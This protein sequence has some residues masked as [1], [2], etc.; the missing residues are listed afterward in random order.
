[1]AN[2]VNFSQVRSN[3]AGIDIGSREIFVSIDGVSAV[4]FPTYTADYRQ[5]C[6][7]LL[8]HGITDVAM[9]ATG[10]Y[11]ISLYCML[12]ESGIYVCLVHPREVQQVKGRKSDVQDCQ[13]IQRLFVSGLLRESLIPS[14]LLKE[15]RYLSRERED[16]IQTGSM[17]VNKMQRALELMNIKLGN[18]ISQ[19]HGASGLKVLHAILEGERDP[20]VLLSLCHSSIRHKKGEDVKKALE[21]N[22][23]ASYLY[24][25]KLNLDMWEFFQQKLLEVEQEMEKLLHVLNEPGKDIPVESKSKPAR[26]HNP[27]IK[28]LHVLMVQLYG[29][30]DLTNIAGINDS[31]L[32]RLYTEIGS[33]LSRFPDMK[34]FCSWLG[35]CPAHKQSGKMKRRI[36]GNPSNVAGQIFRQSAQSLLESKNNAI[37]A[38]MR[39]LRSRKGAR[40]AIKAGARKIAQAYYTALTIGIEYVEQGAEWY[41]EQQRLREINMLNKLAEKLDYKIVKSNP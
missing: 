13:W 40:I 5:C 19:I 28:N 24:M 36:R 10:I 32:M 9:E 34:H 15:L 20:D 16:L 23:N 12:E 41:K 27:V 8:S 25:L 35:L 17:Y 39:R 11:W 30:I 6:N 29:G 4:S 1:M 26:H 14:G 7:Y 3:G 22:Y 37:G 33:D 21:G 18:V 31:T 2:I 38:F